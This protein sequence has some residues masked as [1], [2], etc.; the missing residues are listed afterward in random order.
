[1][2][3][4]IGVL[5]NPSIADFDRTKWEHYKELA[6]K[7][8]T[9]AKYAQFRLD[10]SVYRDSR[11]DLADLRIIDGQGREV[12]Y[13]L[14]EE[15][16][17]VTET[18]YTPTLLNKSV[19]EG[20][21][22]T[23]VLDLGKPGIL[24]NRL[25]IV[26]PSSNFMQ[27]VDI[28]GSQDALRWAVLRN[29][30]YIFSFSRDYAARSTSVSYPENNYRY[31]RVRIWNL[32]EKPVSVDSAVVYRRKVEPAREMLLY[33]GTGSITQNTKDRSTDIVLDMGS[34]GLPAEKV[35]IT[36]PD[37]G[38]DREVQIEESKDQREWANMGSGYI[39][40]YDLPN[41]KGK[42][43][44]VECYGSGQ[45]YIRVRIMN[46]DD[47]PITVSKVQVYGFSRRMV[48]PYAANLEYQLYY[49]NEY[50]KSPVYDFQ[51]TFKYVASQP[52]VL[53]DL[54]PGQK[55]TAFSRPIATKPW[56]EAN[57]WVLWVVLVVAVI[58]L[59]LLAINLIRQTKEDSQTPGP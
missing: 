19:V 51:N 8:D 25:T 54:G 47:Q 9:T 14:I 39:M 6:P 36:S 1:M 15:K 42:E 17:E 32:A 45:R 58:L 7:P 5:G 31:I 43:S 35:V 34:A 16:G 3:F 41:F 52:M 13:T 49:G 37:M 11:S 56:L 23:F 4:L 48:L 18:E 28:A 2:I 22:V 55:N 30:G 10:K 21:Y 29:D 24:N 26:I 33:S 44:S 40:A 50:A 20:K 27:R 46:Y 12:P 53:M 57:P 59:G 38:Y